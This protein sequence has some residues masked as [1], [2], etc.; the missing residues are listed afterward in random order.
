[1]TTGMLHSSEDTTYLDRSVQ[2]LRLCL[3]SIQLAEGLRQNHAGQAWSVI[4]A[5]R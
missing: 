4:G 2:F 3:L 1:M 5:I